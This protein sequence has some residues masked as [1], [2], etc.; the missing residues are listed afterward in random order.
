MLKQLNQLLLTFMFICYLISSASA[1]TLSFDREAFIDE[2]S[3]QSLFPIGLGESYE[4]V[5]AHIRAVIRYIQPPQNLTQR[6][7]RLNQ[8]PFQKVSFLVQNVKDGGEAYE[9]YYLGYYFLNTSRKVEY[10][11]LLEI[12]SPIHNPQTDN[13]P[14]HLAEVSTQYPV[15]QQLKMQRSELE[16]YRK[17]VKGNV[18][19]YYLMYKPDQN[20]TF[21]SLLMESLLPD[22]DFRAILA[23][24][25][26]NI[27][28]MLKH[29]T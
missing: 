2:N 27:L 12:V 7:V 26:A 19:K 25:Q 6:Q 15:M 24:V 1:Q 29:T 4:S 16:L 5:F 20:S 9:Y 10:Y 3:N 8:K 14:G 18:Y 13:L 17:H 23:D 21:R 28:Q 22:D 11:S